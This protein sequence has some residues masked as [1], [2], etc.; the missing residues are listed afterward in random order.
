MTA[1]F[2]REFLSYFTSP[3]GYVFLGVFFAFSGLFLWLN[4]L[5]VGS[6]DMS[7]IFVMMFYVIVILVPILTMRTIADDK[8]QRT[9][10]L[11]LTSPVSL[12]GLVGG[13]FLAAYAVFM[14][15]EMIMLIYA[16]FLS[17]AV[18][19]SGSVFAWNTFRGNFVGIS[20]IGGVF[21]SVGIFISSLTENQ[22]IAAIG[23]IGAN[24]ALCVFDILNSIIKAE[25]AQKVINSLSVFTRYYEFTLGVFSLRNILFFVSLI[26]VFN[27]LTMR[28]IERRRWS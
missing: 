17:S 19:V 28:F 21:I 11:T 2:K 7:G 26:A 9:D 4:C 6:A 25:A 18:E 20:L 3:L 22:M 8:R 23:S 10:Q 24:I 15:S 27:F 16:V 5:A 12:L 13:K 1:I 14:L